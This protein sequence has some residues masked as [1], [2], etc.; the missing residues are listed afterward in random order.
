MDDL[1]TLRNMILSANAL[2]TACTF[3][4]DAARYDSTAAAPLPALLAQA[5]AYAQKLQAAAQPFRIFLDYDVQHFGHV[6]P[7][8]YAAIQSQKH[9]RSSPKLATGPG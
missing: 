5:R 3:A 8:T 9:K 7:Q 1:H 2:A 6:R 4:A